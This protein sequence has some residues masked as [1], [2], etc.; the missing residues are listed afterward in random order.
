MIGAIKSIIKRIPINFTK[1]QVYD[2]QTRKIFKKSLKPGSVF[3]DIGAHKGEVLDWA[4]QFA[5]GTSHYGF[6]AIPELANSLKKNYPDHNIHHLALADYEGT[7]SFHHVTS[8]P[9]YS[10]IKQREYTK[11]ENISIIEVAVNTLDNLIPEEQKVTLI[12]IDVEGGELQVLKGA[13]KTI[14]RNKPVIVFEHG[15]GASEFYENGPD[16]IWEL[17]HSE[18]GM[19]ISLMKNYLNGGTPLS[20]DEFKR[21]YHQKVNYYFVA[22]PG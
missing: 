19:N 21:Q 18:L 15:L 2:A 9:A 20:R 3:I 11:E 14:A 13:K 6:E 8:N 7:T 1:N 10:G 12:K 5:P 17:L 4:I 22:Y 16:Q